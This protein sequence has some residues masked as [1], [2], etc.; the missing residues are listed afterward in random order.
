MR[1][2][3]PPYPAP[4]ELSGFNGSKTMR[5]LNF[6]KLDKAFCLVIP[7]LCI[8]PIASAEWDGNT[9]VGIRHDSNINNAQLAND[10]AGVSALSADVSATG[11]FPL[12]NGNSLSI[13]G[14]S[15]GEAFN[16]YTGLN[17][18]SLGA[19][20][21]F[22]KKWALGAYAPWT[23]LSL[24]STHLNFANNIRNGW[25][26]QIAIRGGKRIFERWDVRAEY[27]VERRTAN[28]LPQDQPGISGDVFSQTSRAMTLNAEYTW[29]DSLFLT[30]GSLLRHG[31]VVASAR[32]TTKIISSSQAIARDPVFGPN[33][34]AYRMNG[35]TYGLNV[36]MNFAVTSSSMLRASISRQL[37]HTE[38]DNNYAKSVQ[39]ISWNYN[40]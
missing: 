19:A 15:R 2:A 5:I 21:A 37:T 14:E 11:F 34:Y 26:N 12:E 31:D 27:M 1:H 9:D 28:T 24:S 30:F 22:R 32:E 35:T 10:I 36:D 17:N 8:S 25:R 39:M 13:T 4:N 40:F 7:L 20:L 38:G 23:G 33:F 16:H 6:K 3:Y 18:I 29:S